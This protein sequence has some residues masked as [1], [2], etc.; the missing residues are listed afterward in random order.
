MYVVFCRFVG[1]NSMII[2]LNMSNTYV[3][4][5]VLNR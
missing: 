5:N 3:K 4:Y 2:K 1:S